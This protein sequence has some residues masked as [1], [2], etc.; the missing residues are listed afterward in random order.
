[1]PRKSLTTLTGPVARETL[2]GMRDPGQSLEPLYESEHALDLLSRRKI[3]L[4]ASIVDL[5]AKA[6]AARDV[7]SSQ[8]EALED[9]E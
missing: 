5:E 3:E 1:M 4:P 7:I 8:R 2:P 9:A 6:Q